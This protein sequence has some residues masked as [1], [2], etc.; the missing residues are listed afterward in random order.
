LA[1]VEER[2]GNIHRAAHLYRAVLSGGDRTV[3]GAFCG[4]CRA[5]LPHW[6]NLCPA[7][8]AFGAVTTRTSPDEI[9]L[10]GRIASAPVYP[11]S[12]V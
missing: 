8:G 7:C 9:T 3:P 6:V 4:C 2:R 12:E 10:T 1:Q 11:S 5:A